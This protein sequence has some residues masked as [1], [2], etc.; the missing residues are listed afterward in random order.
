MIT[1]CVEWRVISS[2]PEK[3]I[4]ENV[5]Q[6]A[7]G[8]VLETNGDPSMKTIVINLQD[9]EVDQLKKKPNRCGYM[10]IFRTR[11]FWGRCI[12]LLLCQMAPL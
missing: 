9:E 1:F 7:P 12:R 4:F 5:F 6:Y 2:L 8:D 10:D 3:A 11:I